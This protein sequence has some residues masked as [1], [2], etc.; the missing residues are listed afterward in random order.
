MAIEVG[1]S[2]DIRPFAREFDD[3]V[4]W[5]DE[6]GDLKFHDVDRSIDKFVSGN[7]RFAFGSMPVVYNDGACEDCGDDQKYGEDRLGD[8][9][10]CLHPGFVTPSRSSSLA[11]SPTIVAG[12]ASRTEWLANWAVLCASPL[13]IQ[14]VI[15]QGCAGIEKAKSKK[16]AALRVIV[17]R[18]S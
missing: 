12:E 17:R 1:S 10:P 18:N 3:E 9:E 4:D 14:G 11:F 7:Q 8:G 13:E 6:T 5:F 15:A 2:F 16:V